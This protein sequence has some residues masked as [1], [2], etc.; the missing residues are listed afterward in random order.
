[1]NL[2]VFTL[3]ALVDEF[4][5]TLAGGRVQDVLDVDET[6]IGLEIY[7]AHRR[8]YLLLSADHQQPRV[9]V[10][11][12]RLRRGLIRPTQLGLLFRRKVEGGIIAHISQP[13][14]ERILHFDIEG[15]EGAVTLIIEP[16]ERRSNLLLVQDGVILDCIRRVGPD[17]NRYRVSLPNQ[18]YHPPPPQVGKL[19]P[20]DVAD[21]ALDAVFAAVEDPKRR[22]AQ[23]LSTAV[24]GISP[25][26]AREIIA[27]A[28]L[29]V[30]VRAHDVPVPGVLA[31]SLRETCAP[32][33]GR[34]W[35][36]GI[37][38]VGERVE[39]F[40][41]YPLT[42][43]PGWRPTETMSD[44]LTAFYRTPEGYDAYA[45]AKAPVFE[46]IADGQAKLRAKL[47]SLQRSM[48]DESERHA[49]RT[50]GE[51][52]LAYQWSIAPGQAVLSAAI[53]DAGTEMQIALDPTLSPLENAQRYFDRYNRA[54][55]AL[56][57]V[58]ERIEETR[59][60][61]D[62]LE[63]LRTDL[64]LAQNW[65]EIDEVQAVLAGMGYL[66][67]AP[68]ARPGGQKSAPLRIITPDGF[69]VWVGRNSRQNDQVTFDKGSPND[70]WL[71]VR[72]VPGAHVIVKTDG[73]TPPDAVLDR[74][75]ALA[76]WYSA[77]RSDAS[78]VVD[79][80]FRRYVRKI[81]GG[82][83]GQVTYSNETTR[84]VRPRSEKDA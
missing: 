24:L 73:R 80:T 31:R 49:L 9:H 79:V 78:V 63:Q 5:D 54:K 36:P 19:S 12:E 30:D 10:V 44:A 34:A 81:K 28:G 16:M 41:A 39:A 43:V 70:L 47:A 58:P 83:P 40:S 38:G 18:P 15:P 2:D 50:A 33:L 7:G 32:L 29:P 59:N 64:E 26:L 57:D 20:A 67:A 65:P 42:S 25:L 61:A 60:D 35:Q 66:R 37:A 84:T 1:M 62:Y 11:P 82:G 21:D 76:A 72:G 51:M 46:A 17:E 45:A 13:P 55:R 53:D 48:T 68:T 4:L 8:R 6:E 77:K 23:V 22:A 52:I 71:H 69:T 74:A 56:D 75:A 3:S 14:F 27:R